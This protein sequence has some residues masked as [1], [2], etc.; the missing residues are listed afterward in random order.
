[1]RQ[2][3]LPKMTTARL[4]HVT[5]TTGDYRWSPRD[6]VHPDVIEDLRPLIAECERTGTTRLGAP[7]DA[8]ILRRLTP[9]QPSRHVA[10]WAISDPDGPALV[11]L[12]IAMRA[13]P[14]AGLW[15][16]LCAGA[17]A[18]Y[19]HAGIQ[20]HGRGDAPP[21]APWLAATPHIAAALP[22]PHPALSWL[23]DAERCIAWAWIDEIWS[24]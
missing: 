13:R 2:D 20:I 7:D 16:T 15:R 5:V 22:V 10:V 14:A 3:D 23:G 18:E 17:Q 9:E 21:P 4:Y 24:E 12:A 19:A 11:T 1:M 6:E 8:L